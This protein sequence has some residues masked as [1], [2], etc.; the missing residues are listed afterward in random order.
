[1]SWSDF[2]WTNV[3]RGIVGGLTGAASGLTGGYAGS[4]LGGVYG[5]I[6]T[7]TDSAKGK[8][9]Q[10][11]L[12]QTAITTSVGGLAFAPSAIANSPKSGGAGTLSGQ[13]SVLSTQAT[14]IPSFLWSSAKKVSSGGVGIAQSALTGIGQL[15]SKGGYPGVLKDVFQQP[16]PVNVSGAYPQFMGKANDVYSYFRDAVAGPQTPMLTVEAGS[17]GGAENLSPEPGAQSPVQSAGGGF[18]ALMLAGAA[19]GVY[20]LW[21]KR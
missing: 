15:F 17:P 20:L 11:S 19:I 21:K 18:S 10:R 12:Y 6:K 8:D 2:N 5:G 13:L 9:Y 16:T 14:E 1:M 7:G 3:G 4:I